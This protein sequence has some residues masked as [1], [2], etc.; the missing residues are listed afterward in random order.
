MAIP[1]GRFAPD[2]GVSVTIGLVISLALRLSADALFLVTLATMTI[3]GLVLAI[4]G[5]R[6]TGG[7]RISDTEVGLGLIGPILRRDIHCRYVVG[8]LSRSLHRV[9]R[10]VYAVAIR[11]P[12]D[13][14]ESGSSGLP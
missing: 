7:F 3:V 1:V 14:P 2:E 6:T 10:K 4:S 9:R 5:G 12:R 11:M 8:H 13:V